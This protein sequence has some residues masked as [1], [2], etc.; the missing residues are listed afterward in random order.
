MLNCVGAGHSYEIP[1]TEPIRG[2]TT[3]DDHGGE[4]GGR[5]P[6]LQSESLRRL[7]PD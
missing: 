1:G 3:G 4:R 2:G 7:L 5:L 6:N